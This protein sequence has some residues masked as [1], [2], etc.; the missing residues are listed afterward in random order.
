MRASDLKFKVAP[1]VTC[2]ALLV[3]GV[4]WNSGL[5]PVAAATSLSGTFSLTGSLNTARY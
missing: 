5:K 4:L 2:S 3:A 1:T